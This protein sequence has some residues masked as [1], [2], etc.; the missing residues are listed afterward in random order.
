MT[1]DLWEFIQTALIFVYEPVVGY[2][3]S[4]VVFAGVLIPVYMLVLSLLRWLSG[5]G[6][7]I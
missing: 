3:L 6:A 2:W 4:A 1:A 5:K 7:M